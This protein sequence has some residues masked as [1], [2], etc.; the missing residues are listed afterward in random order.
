MALV[1]TSFFK[2][3]SRKI[4]L[5]TFDVVDIVE[6]VFRDYLCTGEKML[7]ALDSLFKYCIFSLDF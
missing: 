5:S 6:M 3:Q 4:Y 1:K 7:L 2:G